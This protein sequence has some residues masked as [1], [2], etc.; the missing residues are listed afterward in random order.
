MVSGQWWCQG[1][2]IRAMVISGIR[3]MQTDQLK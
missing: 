3:V 1:N 2:G